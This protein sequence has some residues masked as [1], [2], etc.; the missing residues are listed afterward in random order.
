[1]LGRVIDSSR[2]RVT[3]F[4]G[5]QGFSKWRSPT[6]EQAALWEWAG[7]S[8]DPPACPPPMQVTVL[9][10]PAAMRTLHLPWTPCTVHA[11]P[12]TDRL[13]VARVAYG[14]EGCC[15]SAGRHSQADG[16][17]HQFALMSLAGCKDNLKSSP[18]HMKQAMASSM[19]EGPMHVRRE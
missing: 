14:P 4:C 1:M 10:R 13:K 5:C 9:P 8:L 19:H 15:W 7:W 16:H 6:T 17:E 18:S 3:R 12:C 2:W 11:S